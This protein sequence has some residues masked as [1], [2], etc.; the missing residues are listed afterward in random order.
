M[1][2]FQ[3]G[4]I[5]ILICCVAFVSCERGQ[6]MM[7]PEPS[8]D[9]AEPNP[10]LGEVDGG[11]A[12]PNPMPGDVDGDVAGSNPMPV[13]EDGSVAG[14]TP[15]PGDEDGSVAGS[16][17]M[18]VEVDGGV[19]DATGGMVRIAAGEF[20]MGSN[21]V[22]GIEDIKPVHTVHVDAF[23]IDTHE[24]TNAEYREFVLANPRWQKARFRN[25]FYLHAWNGNNYPSGKGNHPVTNVSWHAAMAYAAWVGKRLPTEAEWEK[26][27]RGGLNGAKYPWGDR[28]ASWHAN[29]DNALGT[30]AVGSYEP[31]GFG[32]YDVAGNVSEW[33]LDAYDERFYAKSPRLSLNPIAG[34]PIASLVS[35][36]ERVP[37]DSRRVTR[38][39]SWKHFDSSM[40]VAHR[41]PSVS[42][43]LSDGI[44]F[45]CVKPA[46]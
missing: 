36:P 9:G 2:K 17:P 8:P 10:M 35:N 40:N 31:N 29:Y 11:V 20:Q 44:G 18:P 25:P 38:G 27:A 12:E 19:S 26:A 1:Q 30:E 7:T 15:M 14:S 21:D 22:T 32:L 23:D 37:D 28:I 4:L 46:P 39:G 6:Q 3:V 43:N 16:T 24:V 13:D 41:F 45:R 42:R 5:A 34:E 33:C